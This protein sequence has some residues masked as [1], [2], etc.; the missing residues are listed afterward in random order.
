LALLWA[1]LTPTLSH[2]LSSPGDALGFEIC[3]ATGPRTA[4]TGNG[5][6][7]E[8]TAPASLATSLD[9]CPYCTL[10]LVA[11]APPPVPVV[12][13]LLPLRFAAPLPDLP[14]TFAPAAWQHAPPRGP[15]L[16]V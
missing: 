3:S 15:P 12:V 14:A 10:H 2:A 1:A 8:P 11:A 5:S 9:H 6:T 4:E 16:S 13:A 7:P